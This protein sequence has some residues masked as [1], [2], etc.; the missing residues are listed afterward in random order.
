MEL[1]PFI[2]QGKVSVADFFSPIKTTLKGACSELINTLGDILPKTE[3]CCWRFEL[4]SFDEAS[5]ST[6]VSGVARLAYKSRDRDMEMFG[7]G[8]ADVVN[9]D[10]N[11]DQ[12]FF[13]VVEKIRMKSLGHIF[14]RCQI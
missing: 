12:P 7:L 6:A 5:F 9:K 13:K 10:L 4:S 8:A 14:W 2:V 11:G 1:P 3:H